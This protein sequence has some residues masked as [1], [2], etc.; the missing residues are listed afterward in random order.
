MPLGEPRAGQSYALAVTNLNPAVNLAVLVF[1]TGLLPPPGIDLGALLGMP[2]CMLY[3][4]ADILVVAPFGV[5][6]TT[7]WTWSPVSGVV[8]ATL[9]S[10][11]LCLDPTVNAF[12]FTVSNAVTIRIVN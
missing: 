3:D 4:S 8:G 1:G 2:G 10:Q 6:G 5:G 12:G 11:A 9:H 7:T